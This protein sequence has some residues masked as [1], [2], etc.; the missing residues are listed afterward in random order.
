VPSIQSVLLAF[1]K[2]RRLSIGEQT[3][4]VASYIAD[5]SG[6]HW[7]DFAWDEDIYGEWECDDLP[8]G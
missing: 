7:E 1:S 8:V 2:G 3:I 5:E 6:G 4:L